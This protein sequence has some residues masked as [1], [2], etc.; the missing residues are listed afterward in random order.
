MPILQAAQR[1]LMATTAMFWAAG[2]YNNGILPF[3]RSIVG[4]AYTP[5]GKAAELD[6][7]EHLTES[8][9]RRHG[10][11]PKILP[12]PAWETV[13]TGDVFRVFERGGRVIGSQ[14]PE[15]GN[16]NST[17]EI[18]LLDEPRPA[19]NPPVRTAARRPGC[20]CR[21]RC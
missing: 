5:E 14:F 13:P 15:I 17:G 21:S 3:K 19:G 1:S 8:E 9:M 6:T 10:I 7:P 12:L 18:D 11:I 4:E 16:P 2:A 20:G